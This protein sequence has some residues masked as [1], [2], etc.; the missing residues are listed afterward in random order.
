MVQGA[1][2]FPAGDLRAG[3]PRNEFRAPV[4]LNRGSG[5]LSG[6][7]PRAPPVVPSSFPVLS[8]S[9]ALSAFRL[10]RIS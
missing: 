5:V 2:A 9:S 8:V 4:V 6:W 10:D 7:F 1:A 3:H